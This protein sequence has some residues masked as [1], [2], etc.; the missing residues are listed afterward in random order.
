MTGAQ[1][2][3][4]GPQQELGGRGADSTRE[5][6]RRRQCSPAAVNSSKSGGAMS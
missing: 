6:R 2:A 1:R 4:I 5:P 3:P